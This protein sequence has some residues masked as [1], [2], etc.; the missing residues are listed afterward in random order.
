M[1]CQNLTGRSFVMFLQV[2]NEKVDHPEFFLVLLSL[3]LRAQIRNHG[4]INV[5]AGPGS[6]HKAGRAEC[7]GEHHQ[8]KDQMYF[9]CVQLARIIATHLRKLNQ[10]LF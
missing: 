4:F 5:I 9:G 1:C 3:T 7:S 6:E 8:E 2:E 10:V